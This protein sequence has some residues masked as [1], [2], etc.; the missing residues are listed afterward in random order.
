MPEEEYKHT[1]KE[2]DIVLLPNGSEATVTKWDIV[3]GGNAK[4]VWVRP[5]VGWFWRFIMACRGQTSYADDDI[6]TLQFIG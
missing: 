6:N 5:H 4:V 1:V 3:C 2:G